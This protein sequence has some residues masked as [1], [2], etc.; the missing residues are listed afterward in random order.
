MHL[1]AAFVLA[2]LALPAAAAEVRDCN[3]PEA[4]AF[5]IAEPWE[6][7]TR[8][9][10]N[11]AVRIAVLDTVEPAAASF[12][13]MVIAPPYDELGLPQCRVVS[14]APGTGYGSMTLDGMTSGYDPAR[15]LTLE[16][17]ISAYNPAT[18]GFDPGAL[19]L[20]I[21]Q[22]TGEIAAEDIGS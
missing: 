14:F 17:A 11:G 19:W 6:A 2:C 22:A 21:N 10:A 18:G 7:N 12:H 8:T 1:R 9:F 15:G 16:I 3:G 13:L 20:T 5:W 4:G